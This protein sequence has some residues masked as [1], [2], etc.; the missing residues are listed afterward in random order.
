[1]HCIGLNWCHINNPVEVT[2]RDLAATFKKCVSK[3]SNLFS[4]YSASNLTRQMGRYFIDRSG[5]DQADTVL[6]E[7]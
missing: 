5:K 4:V 1:M 2:V 3:I 6:K 7:N